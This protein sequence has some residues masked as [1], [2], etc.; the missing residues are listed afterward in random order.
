VRRT[1]SSKALRLYWVKCKCVFLCAFAAL[2]EIF[3]RIHAR[4]PASAR[5]WDCGPGGIKMLI[6]RKAAKAQRECKSKSAEI[7]FVEDA[8]VALDQM[9]F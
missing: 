1:R 4:P 5:V 6:S 3:F 7:L 9:E 8:R 2:R